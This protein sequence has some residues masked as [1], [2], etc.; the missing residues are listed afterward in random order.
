MRMTAVIDI[1]MRTI[2]QIASINNNASLV[3]SAG[4]RFVD[5]TVAR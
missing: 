3:V 4:S 1:V 2:P 5:V